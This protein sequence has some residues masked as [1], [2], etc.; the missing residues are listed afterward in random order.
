MFILSR[1]T[2]RIFI[3]TKM[4]H[5]KHDASSKAQEMGHAAKEKMHD[6]ANAVKSAAERAADKEIRADISR[7]EDVV[8]LRAVDEISSS[9]DPW[10]ARL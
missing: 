6:A 2:N 1:D 3:S 9:L 5:H 7:F 4:D 8:Q 10:A